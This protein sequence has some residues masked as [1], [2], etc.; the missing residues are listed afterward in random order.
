MGNEFCATATDLE[1]I[2]M[3]LQKKERGF[4]AVET[5]VVTGVMMVSMAIAAPNFMSTIRAQR[6]SVGA[7][8]ISQS[9]QAV[10]FDA[11][12]TNSTAQVQVDMAT[13]TVKTGAGGFLPLPSG[14]RFAT[15]SEIT[16]LTQEASNTISIVYSATKNATS[17]NGSETIEEKKQ[18]SN[19]GKGTS[20]KLVSGSTYKTS[21]TSRGIPYVVPGAVN[22][23]YLTNG[24]GEFRAITV[25]SAGSI[26]TWRRAADTTTWTK[27]S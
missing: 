11:V 1:R 25:T 13:N 3:K 20:Y 27:V 7:Q 23:V 22:W 2:K 8:Q 21:F 6:L 26:Q 9:L 4:S 12:R 17:I 14:I 18:E 10:K 19:R 24:T 16:A 5:M 15:D